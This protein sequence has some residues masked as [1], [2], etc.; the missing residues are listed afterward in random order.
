MD[1]SE[2][3]MDWYLIKRLDRVKFSL[4]S[5]LLSAVRG[6]HISPL[7]IMQCSKCHLQSKQQPLP[8]D[9]ALI[10]DFPAHRTMRNKC[11]FFENYPVCGYYHMNG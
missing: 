8:D 10:L 7:R 5:F 11:M 9:S 2:G 4:F 1:R 3:F 6:Q